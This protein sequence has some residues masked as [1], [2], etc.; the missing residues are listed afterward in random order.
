MP[1]CR[2]SGERPGLGRRR[3]RGPCCGRGWPRSRA[4]RGRGRAR[5]RARLGSESHALWAPVLAG[6]MAFWP[7]WGPRAGSVVRRGAPWP[8]NWPTPLG[9]ECDA[10]WRDPRGDPTDLVGISG[11]LPRTNAIALHGYATGTNGP[12]EPHRLSLAHR[13]HPVLFIRQKPCIGPTGM[14]RAPVAQHALATVN[15]PVLCTAEAAADA[16]LRACLS[17]AAS[18]H[19]VTVSPAPA[20]S[21]HDTVERL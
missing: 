16:C 21:R 2:R 14:H 17:A 3:A 15:D 8:A 12:G 5:A 7:S 19:V 11:P 13:H 18:A 6:P 9:E 1:G 20:G 4:A 10:I